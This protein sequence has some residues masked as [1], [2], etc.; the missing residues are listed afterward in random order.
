MER[1]RENPM[2][3]DG[4]AFVEFSALVP[5]PLEALF[6]KLGFAKTAVHRARPVSLWRQGD[7][8]ILL[9]GDADTFGGRF[10]ALHGPC[11][12]AIAFNVADGQKSARLALKWGA[13]AHDAGAVKTIDA[14]AIEG[15]GAS[16][17]YLV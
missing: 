11:V 12:S 6:E 8:E 9:N 4:L 2:G 7:I 14:P 15:I 3:T 5:A 17:L 16:L 1:P 13:T 10:A